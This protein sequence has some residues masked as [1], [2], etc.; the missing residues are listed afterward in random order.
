MTATQPPRE[1]HMPNDPTPKPG[2]Q[3]VEHHSSFAEGESHPDIYPDEE[4]VGTFAEGESNPEKY[5]DDEHVGAFAEV[6]K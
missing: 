2:T 5:P 6:R 3:P 1:A 4:H